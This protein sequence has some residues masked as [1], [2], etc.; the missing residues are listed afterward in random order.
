MPRAGDEKEACKDVDGSRSSMAAGRK[1][2]MVRRR[3][4][5]RGR[6]GASISRKQIVALGQQGA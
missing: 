3:D 5:I 1:D 2:R 4:G 6:V